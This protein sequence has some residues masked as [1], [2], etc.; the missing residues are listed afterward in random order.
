MKEIIELA[1]KGGWIKSPYPFFLKEIL[2]DDSRG[3]TVVI[4]FSMPMKSGSMPSDSFYHL[5]WVLFQPDF[6]KC[7]GKALDWP[8]DLPQPYQT[9]NG[10]WLEITWAE[11]KHHEFV[12]H[13]HLGKE[14]IRFF[15]DLL[16]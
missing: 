2:G 10:T 16:K 12:H 15:K 5:E 6:W 1:I 8:L 3:Y 4:R 14:P 7:L 13:V 9:G 11:Y